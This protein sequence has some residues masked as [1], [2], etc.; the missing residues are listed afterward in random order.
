MR[1][2]FAGTPDFAVAAL[3]TLHAAGH[4]IAGVFTQPDRPAGRGRKLTPSPVA[5]RAA[6]LGLAVFKPEKLRA[7]AQAQLRTLAPEVIVVVA[8]GLILPQAVLD[9]PPHGCLNIHASLLPRWRGAAPIQRAIEAG[10]HETGITIMRMDAGLD[11]GP[12]LLKR[13]VPIDEATTAAALHDRLAPLGAELIVEALDRLARGTLIA[14]PQPAEGATYAAKL[15]KEEARIDW[16]QPADV[17]ARRIRAFNPAPVAWSELDGERVRL[18]FARA[19]DTGSDALPGTILDGPGLVVACG[20][21]RL[22]IEQLQ[23]PGGR[24]LDAREALAARQLGGR[25]FV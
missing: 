17:L 1:L 18:L 14:Q 7:E 12:M 8:Y 23:W 3:D 9:I 25:R 20:S 21:G 4:D 19:D 24:V 5:Q 11:T 13:V 22:S 10:D 2:V 15:S 6:A 16:S